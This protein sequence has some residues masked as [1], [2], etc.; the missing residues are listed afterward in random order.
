MVP[1]SKL[2]EIAMKHKYTLIIPVM[3]SWITAKYCEMI[4]CGVIP[5]LH[6]YYD[7][8]NELVPKDHFI[9]VYEPKELWEKIELLENEPLIRIHVVKELQKRWLTDSVRNGIEVYNI[10]N[11]FI[12]PLNIQLDV[13]IE[14]RQATGV[15]LFF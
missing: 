9:R 5:F 4:T 11:R 13:N 7:S 10:L 1:H 15:E 8:N 3:K 2:M 14:E 6:P 12:E